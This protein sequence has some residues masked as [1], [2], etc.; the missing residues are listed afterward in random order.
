MPLEFSSDRRGTSVMMASVSTRASNLAWH[1]ILKRDRHHDGK[2]VYAALTTGI[3]CRPSCPARHPRRRNTLLF[4]RP[5]DAEREGFTPCRRCFP[6]TESPTN[7]EIGIKAALEWIETHTQQPITLATLSQVTGFS[8]NH[9]QQTFKRIV[10]LS[11]KAFCDARRLAHFRQFIKQGA[12]LTDAIYRA[13]YGSSRAL[14]EMA[15]KAM[16]MTPGDYRRGGRATPINYALFPI[17]LGRALI[18]ATH[19]GICTILVGS[20]DKRLVEMLRREFPESLLTPKQSLR[21][22]WIAKI[23]SC[24]KED[25]LLSEL[26]RDLRC[27]IFQAKAWKALQ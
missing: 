14:Y 1:A 16:G 6:K 25:R 4:A 7:A 10:G 9:L 20:D 15:G 11:P 2:F 17:N 26:P 18:A 13:G 3:Y 8:P 19:Q 22:Q 27:R 21:R 23:S 24:Q 12:S 5:A